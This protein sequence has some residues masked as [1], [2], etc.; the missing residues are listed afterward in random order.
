MPHEN[1]FITG[2]TKNALA[3]NILGLFECWHMGIICGIL[4][5]KFLTL[6]R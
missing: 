4:M 3:Q 1:T 6:L 5:G 2:S